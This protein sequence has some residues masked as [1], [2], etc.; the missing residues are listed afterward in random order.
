MG[1]SDE[2]VFARSW[3][4]WLC[5][6]VVLCAHACAAP[7]SPQ[8]DSSRNARVVLIPRDVQEIDPRFS[9]DAYGVKVSRLLFASL[10]TIDSDTL[11]VVPDLAEEVQIVS[12]TQYRAR[13]R[14]G[15]R[16]SDGSALDAQDVAATFRSVVD[17]NFGSRYA[18]T[19]ERIERVEVVDA[20]TVVFHLRGA[21]ATFMTDLEM[22][23]L[24][25]EDE[26]RQLGRLGG[27]PPVGAGPYVLLSRSEGKLELGPNPHWHAGLPRAPDLRLLVVHDDNTR[28]LR[29]LA[30]AADLALNAVPPVLLPLFESDPRFVVRSAPGVGTSYVG[31]NMEAP[32][33]RDVRVRRA[34]AYAIDRT[35]LVAAKLGGRARLASSW[36][37]PGHWAHAQDTPGYPYD[38][39]RARA[40]LREAGV[41]TADAGSVTRRLRLT[42]RCGSDRFRQSVARA[43]SAMWAEVGVEVEIRPSEVATLIADLN[44]G[45]FELTTLEVPEVVEPHVLNWFFGSDHVPG[46][47]R[48]GANRWRLRSARLDAALEAGRRDVRRA[49]RVAA[50]R[51]VQHVLAEQLPVIPLWHEDVVAVTSDRVLDFE[52]PRLGRFEPLAR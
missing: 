39:Q 31:L 35:R 9:G 27:E 37:V 50:Y 51:E 30:G 29:M 5:A 6:G 1:G 14:D 38:P 17:R 28:A 2:T 24:R 49:R 10:V 34:L 16:F 3:H 46:H 40:L 8:G 32:A 21:H 18:R 42:L 26:H 13:L 11:E 4:R 23:V 45:R 33:L 48:E 43:L 19:Y 47:G 52:V 44:R 36:I 20:Q 22:P 12:P 7:S 41:S 25:A 15:L